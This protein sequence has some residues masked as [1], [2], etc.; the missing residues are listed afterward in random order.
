MCKYCINLLR[1]KKLELFVLGI[2]LKVNIIELYC[3]FKFMLNINL[4][5]QKIVKKNEKKE[6]EKHAVVWLLYVKMIVKE[7]HVN[8]YILV[9]WVL[10]PGLI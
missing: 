2:N 7:T 5:V 8:T 3:M 1:K 9:V 10:Y 6:K 4:L